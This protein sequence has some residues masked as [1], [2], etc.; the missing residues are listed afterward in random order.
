VIMASS[1]TLNTKNLEALGAGRLAALLI[2]ISKGNSVAKRRLRLELA[3]AAGGDDA[4]REIHKRITALPRPAHLS[5]GRRR[6]H[7]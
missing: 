1:K 2:E 3:G 6:G 5:T 7:W 4:A